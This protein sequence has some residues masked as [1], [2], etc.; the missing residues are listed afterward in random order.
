MKREAK[1]EGVIKVP[2]DQGVILEKLE[3]MVL[4]GLLGLLVLQGLED[5]LDPLDL[6]VTL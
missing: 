1:E 3:M 5:L 4:R 2:P 6:L